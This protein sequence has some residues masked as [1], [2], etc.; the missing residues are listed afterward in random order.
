MFFN[1]KKSKKVK[2]VLS[3]NSFIPVHIESVQDDVDLSTT[4]RLLAVKR[5]RGS[6]FFHHQWS[7]S[8]VMT[9]PKSMPRQC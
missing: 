6:L 5:E 9:R 8:K 3:A 4:V 7:S 1:E 2:E